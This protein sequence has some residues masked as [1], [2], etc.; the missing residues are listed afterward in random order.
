[1][2]E[3]F[4][5]VGFKMST[6]TLAILGKSFSCMAFAVIYVHTSEMF[7]TEARNLVVGTSKTSCRLSSM[8][9]SYVGGPLVSKGPD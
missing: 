9:S 4:G 8:A 3:S 6:T 7:P 2:K 5:V 1:M